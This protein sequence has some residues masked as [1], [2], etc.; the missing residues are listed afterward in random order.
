MTFKTGGGTTTTPVA[1]MSGTDGLDNYYHANRMFVP[2]LVSAGPDLLL[3]LNEPTDDDGNDAIDA[4]RLW[5]VT[6][7]ADLTDNITNRQQ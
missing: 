7:T 1:V 2:L 6:S 5:V 3:G 4:N